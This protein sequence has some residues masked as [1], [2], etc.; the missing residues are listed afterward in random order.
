METLNTKN[1]EWF[2]CTGLFDSITIAKS[3]DLNT[4]EISED[5]FN[6]VGRTREN[7]GITA[8]VDFFSGDEEKVNKGNCITVVMV[9]DSTCSVFYQSED[10]Y[11]SQNMLIL[12]SAHINKFVGIFLK[13]VIS[14]E[15][16]RFSY[17]RTLTKGYFE[18]MRLK[19]PAKDK[20]P[21]WTFMENYIKEI[22]FKNDNITADP[23]LNKKYDLNLSEWRQFNIDDLFEI[24]GTKTT[25]LLELEEYGIGKYPFVT[26]KATNNGVEGLFDYHTEKGS[27]LVVDSAVLGHCSYQPFDFSASDHVEKLMPKFNID[28]YIAL[29]LTTI[30]NKEKYRYNYGRKASQT[31]LRDRSIKLPSRGDVPDWD[32]MRDYIK[33]LPYSTNL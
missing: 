5:G 21:D 29:F 10:F 6:Y 13:N 7:N 33:S 17:G 31:R 28:K 9:G 32:F 26:T 3:T 2:N 18:T 24:K 14:Q 1:W 4:L 25:P 30:F 19:V 23:I 22:Y 11:S 27:I 16:Y 20:Y 12:R 8:K 15:K